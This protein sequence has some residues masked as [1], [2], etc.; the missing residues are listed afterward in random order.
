MAQKVFVKRI[1]IE[2]VADG[3]QF[4]LTFDSKFRMPKAIVFTR[5]DLTLFDNGIFASKGVL[6]ARIEFDPTQELKGQQL[7]HD[8]GATSVRAGDGRA[9]TGDRDLWWLNDAGW[10][11]P[12]E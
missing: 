3:K 7:A 8:P 1:R 10:F 11:H 12:P 2:Y 5:E 4:S 6:P 9:E